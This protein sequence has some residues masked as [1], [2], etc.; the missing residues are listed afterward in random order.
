LKNEYPENIINQTIDKY[1]SRITLPNQPKPQKETKRFIV[2]PFV[3]K[4]AEDFTVSFKSLVEESYSQV[5]FNVAFK[6]PKT[7]GS[8]FPFKDQIKEK[9]SQSL[10]VYKINCKTCNDDYIER[11][12]VHSLKEHQNKKQ[13]T[14]KSACYEHIE[15]NPTHEFN[16][17]NI[18]GIDRASRSFKLRMKE[19]L[20]ILKEQPELN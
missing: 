3:N 19:L 16:Y 20:H 5:D 10:V 17:E 15:E 6:S 7:I 18:Q 4:K 12:L 11:I 1:I 8:L 14:S 2:L 13:T 9:T